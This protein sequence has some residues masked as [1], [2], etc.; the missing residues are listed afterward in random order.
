MIKG[1]LSY[2]RGMDIFGEEFLHITEQQKTQL[3]SLK[4]MYDY[5]NSRINVVSRKDMDNFNLHHVLH[6]L[7]IARIYDFKDNPRVMD[8]GCGGGF[9]GIPLAICFPETHFHMVDSIGKKIKV[10]NEV[11]NALKLQNITAAHSRAEDIRNRKFDCVISR[12][13]APLRSL[14]TWTGPL[15]D[16]KNKNSYGLIC[17]KGG[18]LAQEISEAGRRVHI[19]EI[20]GHIFKDEWFRDKYILQVKPSSM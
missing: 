12:A 8:L 15:L 5:W 7:S 17:L 16:K 11:S 2:L 4:E 3:L 14:I 9:P 19:T 13:V 10:V 18:D 6:S 20:Y 1:F